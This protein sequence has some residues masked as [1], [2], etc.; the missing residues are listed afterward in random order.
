MAILAR[1]GGVWVYAGAGIRL[2]GAVG[3]RAVTGAGVRHFDGVAYLG[4]RGVCREFV[5]GAGV[6]C[7]GIVAF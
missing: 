3:G 4:Q 1:G 6:Y 2:D 5:R 7:A